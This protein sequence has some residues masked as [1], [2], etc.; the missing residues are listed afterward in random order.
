MLKYKISHSVSLRLFAQFCLMG[1][2][3]KNKSKQ[4][5]TKTKL[6]DALITLSEKKG[7]LNVTI[8]E[9]CSE[10]QVHRSTFYRYYENKD[11]L[12]R[13]LEKIHYDAMESRSKF[14]YRMD[15]NSFMKSPE[16]YEKE[17]IDLWAYGLDNKRVLRFLFTP[18]ADYHF[19][20]SVK[21]GMFNVF[22][23]AL[24]R[25]NLF[26]EEKRY[27]INFFVAGI[28]AVWYDYVSQEDGKLNAEEMASWIIVKIKDLIL[29]F[30]TKN[31]SKARF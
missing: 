7:F 13:E 21:V 6:A 2:D 23:N 30:D 5:Q 19:T 27:R 16:I 17:L 18:N 29:D 26:Q 31:E 4:I 9:I 1:C 25:S 11:V 24:V 15:Y 14:F 8:E 22:K 3:V 28:I 12:L 20:R 10:A